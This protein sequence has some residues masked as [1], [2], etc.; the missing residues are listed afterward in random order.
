MEARFNLSQKV[1]NSFTCVGFCA[2]YVTTDFVPDYN[3]NST[4]I[5]KIKAFLQANKGTKTARLRGTGALPQAGLIV[6]PT[7][8]VRQGARLAEESQQQYSQGVMK[9][10][11]SLSNEAGLSKKTRREP[12]TE[13]LSQET[14]SLAINLEFVWE[15]SPD[16][17][18]SVPL[19]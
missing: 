8:A 3:I 11:R 17:D 2:W 12:T 1:P 9:R 19:F 7:G 18:S 6:D 4:Y 16:E 15:G 13:V 14:S 10:T 5:K